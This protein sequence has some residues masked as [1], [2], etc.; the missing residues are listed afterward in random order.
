M[1]RMQSKLIRFLLLMVP[2]LF[3]GQVRITGPS[4]S[5]GPYVVPIVLNSTITSIFTAGDVVS[6]Y[7]MCGLPDGLG[8]YD[9]GDGS[10]CVLMNHE[11]SAGLSNI[12]A[13]GAAGAFVS[14]WTIRKSDLAV[15]SGSDLIQNINLWNGSG[16]T[17]YSATGPNGPAT[18]QRFCS[19]DLAPV[20][21]FYN[22]SSGS[23]TTVRIFMNGEENSVFG[24]AFA[25]IVTGPDAGTSYELPRLGKASWEN[26]T[27]CPFMQDKTIVA[28]TDDSSPGQV[29]I[30][31]GNKTNTGTA[32]DR[33]GLMNGKLFGVA[34]SN[35]AAES[36]AQQPPLTMTFSLIDLGNV[37]NTDG[38]ALENLSNINKVTAFL[39]P[40]DGCWD[41]SSPTDFYFATTSSFNNNS[42]LWR[43][44][45][46]NISQP[47]SGGIITPVLSG[48]EGQQMLDNLTIDWGGNI[49]LQEDVGNNSHLGKIWSYN[50][51]SKQLTA[52]AQHDSARFYSGPSFLTN[53]E[54]SSGI[55]DMTDILGAGYYLFVS[56]AHYGLP[57]PMVEGGQLL[58]MRM[59]SSP[60]IP[61]GLKRV[62]DQMVTVG[63]TGS[64]DWSVM[65][66]S[67]ADIHHLEITDVCGRIVYSSEHRIFSGKATEISP[68]SFAPGLYT[69]KATTT[70]GVYYFRLLK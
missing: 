28:M 34:V 9:N 3:S 35:Y 27:A 55:I 68:G 19:A 64:G 59:G 62:P 17:S 6:G 61:A 32:P 52:I 70:E 13:H 66:L 12:H 11:F 20:P 56:E 5:A 41:P 8:A 60:P 18:V 15:I 63:L 30:Y 4:S 40:E 45:F 50:K 23:G 43:L 22:Q 37:S 29:Y 7:T 48:A 1:K 51:Y 53:D 39:R 46:N 47:E 65:N 44:R 10:F 2:A 24:R 69:I 14:K 31:I 26:A 54:E 36:A 42:R 67:P 25:H 21:A 49:L 57:A 33:A 58:L 38:S 16:Y